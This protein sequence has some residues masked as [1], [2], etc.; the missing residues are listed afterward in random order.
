MSNQTDNPLQVL[1]GRQLS[2]VEFVHDYIQL[3]FE[4]ATLSAMTLPRVCILDKTFESESLGYRDALCERIGQRI[5]HALTIPENEIRI[6]FNDR[7]TISISLA[8]KDYRTPEAA[9]FHNGDQ[10]VVW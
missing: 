2:S 4:G 8:S 6:V 1:E 3:H 9:V 7:S 5:S 10:I